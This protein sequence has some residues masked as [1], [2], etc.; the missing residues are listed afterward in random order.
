ML[1]NL[2]RA[3]LSSFIGDDDFGGCAI[4]LLRL[5]RLRRR[6][7]DGE[8]QNDKDALS[9]SAYPIANTSSWYEPV[10]PQFTGC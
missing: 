9:P 5:P 10:T 1:L 6:A 8:R 7:Q 4:K 2:D 3:L